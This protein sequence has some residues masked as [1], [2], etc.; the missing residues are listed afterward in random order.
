MMCILCGQNK[1]T[2]PDRNRQGRPVARLRVECHR[3]RLTNDMRDVVAE[4]LKRKA[5]REAE[6]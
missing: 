1:A 2:V 5:K 4:F 6:G 3:D